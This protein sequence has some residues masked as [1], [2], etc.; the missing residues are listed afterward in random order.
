MAHQPEGTVE[1]QGT[2]EQRV[3]QEYHLW[4]RAWHLVAARAVAAGLG[5]MFF[6]FYVVSE[7]LPGLLGDVALTI[8]GIAFF[9]GMMLYLVSMLAPVAIFLDRNRLDSADGWR[10]SLWYYIIAI[11]G[12]LLAIPLAALY[13]YKRLAYVGFASKPAK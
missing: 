3:W 13:T 1:G 2:K 5:V 10:P 7:L 6:A 8:S 11:P 12:S 9:L 4:P